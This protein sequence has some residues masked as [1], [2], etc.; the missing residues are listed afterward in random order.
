MAGLNIG[1]VVQ[2]TP[3]A[4]MQAQQ[5]REAELRNNRPEIQSLASHVRKAWDAA[6]RAKEDKVDPR[7]L[8]AVRR[9]R[10]EYDPT[11]LADI[12]K[13]GGSE[14]Y[15]TLAANKCRAGFAW[16]RDV[17]LGDGNEK[18]WSL[19]ATS[20]PELSPKDMQELMDEAITYAMEMMQ[21]QGMEPTQKQMD[22]FVDT[23]RDR[24]TAKLKHEAKEKVER[25]EAKMQD[26]L[27]EGGFA[28][29]FSQ[30]LD[31][32]MTFPAAIMKGPVVRKRQV[33]KWVQGGPQGYMLDVQD[34][35]VY[36]WERVDP[37][38]LYPAP[39]A[40]SI[41]DGY[42]IERHK[43]TR[44]SIQALIGVE[45]YSEPALRSVLYQY[46]TG[47]LNDWLSVD[48]TRLEA[49]GKSTTA[50]MRASPDVTI[51][52]LQYWGSVQGKLLREW[53]L[54]DVASDTDEYN[55]EVWLIGNWVVKAVVNPDPLGRKPYYKDSFEDIP[56]AFWGN[57][58]TDLVADSEDMCNSTARA[59]ANNMGLS[60]GPQVA[61]NVSRLAP[62]EELTNMYPWKM[63][64]TQDSPYGDSSPP[65]NFF[66]PNSN[67][68]ELMAVY[69][70][71]ST[72]ADE[73][74]GIP[75]YMTGDANVGG[76][77]RTASGMSMMMSNAGKTIKH[78]IASL[79]TNVITQLLERLYFYNMKYSDDMELKGDV[80]VV[81]RGVDALMVKEQA[82]VRRNEFMNIVA[83]NPV[84]LQ[85]VGEEAIA[86][87][88]R[89]AAKSLDMDVDKIVPPPEIIRARAMAR[90]Q[91]MQAMQQGPQVM[92]GNA[93][94][95]PNG[96]P[97]TDTFAPARQ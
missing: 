38:M 97:V 86:A 3:L 94:M 70:K 69:E 89:E 29:S 74:S 65:I 83:S 55:C 4:D 36:E 22:E 24:V 33:L 37:F 61:V 81:A 7:L 79:G 6:R 1:G 34:D 93:Q 23:V 87:L 59:L 90:E 53:G 88:L 78:V 44:L 21:G 64:Q 14:I 85:I 57:G 27:Q 28:A 9:R 56:G 51:D 11:L 75:R 32:L 20:V 43:L 58:V 10:G 77:G 84:F 60:S 45:G 17:M 96:Q 95:L 19:T 72:L 13:I 40:S 52:A 35:F 46:G 16:L 71:F 91:Q 42:L 41:D 76:A 67:A 62:G 47:G 8:A 73:H 82:Q 92:P 50:V 66:Q 18:P 2:I 68:A 39:H 15:M 63:W 80:K 12:R 49:E 5:R 30:F 25:M 31:D 48:V 54:A 26:Q